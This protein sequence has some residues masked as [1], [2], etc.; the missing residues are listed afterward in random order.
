MSWAGRRDILGSA[1]I[2]VLRDG[3]PPL[4]RYDLSGRFVSIMRWNAGNVPVT[5]ALYRRYVDE[6]L[7]RMSRGY[8][9][10]LS[11]K[12]YALDLPLPPFLPSYQNLLVAE[13]GTI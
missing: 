9:R 7:A 4:F 6:E 10:D 1:S 8:F 12:Y 2:L 13:D 5:S 3:A 11:V